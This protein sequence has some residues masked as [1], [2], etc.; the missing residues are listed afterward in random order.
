MPGKM[1]KS[2]PKTPSIAHGTGDPTVSG[3]R[4]SKYVRK[5]A[6]IHHIEAVIREIPD[7]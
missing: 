7:I 3:F 6:S 1:P 4:A 5:S 2:G